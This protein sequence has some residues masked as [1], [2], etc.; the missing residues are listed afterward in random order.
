M[1]FAHLS[2]GESTFEPQRNLLAAGEGLDGGGSV[3]ADNAGN[4]YVTWHRSP[5]GSREA[6]GGAWLSVSAD[7]G[8]SFAPGRMISPAGLGQCGCCGMKAAVSRTGEVYVLYRSAAESIHRDTILLVS[9]DHGGTFQSVSV[10]PW[11]INACPM[12]AFSL[13]DSPSGM[14]AAWET[15][16][17]VSLAVF[18][19]TVRKL[20][21]PGVGTGQRKY[22]VA[23]GSGN[24]SILLAWVDGAGWARGGKLQWMVCDR[25]GRPTNETGS[26]DGVPAWSLISAIA[27]PDGGF[28]VYY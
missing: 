21:T 18:N 26:I 10:D 19:T 9:R 14:L 1:A 15:Q 6:G 20:I 8:K 27:L 11:N 16:G 5:A 12:S 4:V 2:Q 23:I 3:A 13:S 28:L 25:S 7:D 24:G 17:Q 22:P